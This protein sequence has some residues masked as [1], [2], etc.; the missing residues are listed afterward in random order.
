MAS[1][2]LCPSL[3]LVGSR[4]GPF[5]QEHAC[6]QVAFQAVGHSSRVPGLGLLLEH[7][8]QGRQCVG[9]AMLWAAHR[10]IRRVSTTRGSGMGRG[11]SLYLFE[12]LSLSVPSCLLN[13]SLCILAR[14]S[15]GQHP[16]VVLWNC[17]RDRDCPA[18]K[19]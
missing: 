8:G 1:K 3:A 16:L 15:G 13:P 7:P 17:I 12:P 18:C 10:H 4:A 9:G 5:P 11:V 6:L 19:W 14:N 2:G